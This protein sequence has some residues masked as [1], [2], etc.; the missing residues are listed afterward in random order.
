M[1]LPC[2]HVPLLR[3]DNH[4]EKWATT[5]ATQSLQVWAHSQVTNVLATFSQGSPTSQFS[6][7]HLATLHLDPLDLSSSMFT[8]HGSSTHG[9]VRHQ[10]MML[11]PYNSYMFYPCSI[12][13]IRAQCCHWTWSKQVLYR[14]IMCLSKDCGFWEIDIWLAVAET[15]RVTKG[16]KSQIKILD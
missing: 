6:L 15:K 9:H 8:A 1:G 4:D 16:N 2:M 13:I 7:R 5:R 12:F 3:H 11:M 14:D 10:E